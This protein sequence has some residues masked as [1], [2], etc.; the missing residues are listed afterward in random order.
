MRAFAYCCRILTY[1]FLGCG[2][3]EISRWIW[4]LSLLSNFTASYA[5]LQYAMSA[6]LDDYPTLHMINIM[7]H[8]SW[9]GLFFMCLWKCPGL[10]PNEAA[11]VNHQP[12]ADPKS[13]TNS[14]SSKDAPLIG[15]YHPH[16]YDAALHLM[17]T[18]MATEDQAAARIPAVCHTCR[19]QKP[20]RSKHCKV[21]RKC[22]CKFDH[23]W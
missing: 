3:A 4:R 1:L 13:A 6:V 15:G 16:S 23:F 20:L 8:L 22:V 12:R 5:T 14:T 21:A 9:W 18:E 11:A 17:G 10:V 7:M 19:V 2:D